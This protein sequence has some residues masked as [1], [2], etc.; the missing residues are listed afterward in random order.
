MFY[1]R[2]YNGMGVK[3][4]IHLHQL[5]TPGMV[6]LNLY[7]PISFHGVLLNYINNCRANFTFTLGRIS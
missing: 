7:L 5:Q 6:E 1:P 4:N 2:D 3:L